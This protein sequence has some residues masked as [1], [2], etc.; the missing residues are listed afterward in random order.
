MKRNLNSYLLS[1]ISPTTQIND[2]KIKLEGPS[3]E[4]T[5]GLNFQYSNVSKSYL[6]I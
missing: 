4:D 2:R 6:N 5:V 1:R 3:N